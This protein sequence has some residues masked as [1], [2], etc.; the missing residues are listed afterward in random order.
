[1][2]VLFVLALIV[3]ASASR[4]A[5]ATA[6]T[7]AGSNRV[8]SPAVV[9]YW[10]SRDNGD[11]TGVLDLLVLWRGSPAWFTRGSGSSGGGGS[12]GGFGRWYAYQWMS[13]GDITLTIEL[14]SDAKGF[15]ADT[16]TAAILG[17]EI[18]L[19]DANVVL[20]DGADSGNPTIVGTRHVDPWF[21]GNDPVSAVVRRSPELFEFLRCDITL[22]DSR[23]QTMMTFVCGRMRP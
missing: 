12:S 10:Q 18:S 20:I 6:Q 1:M 4:S 14:N 19:R 23:M 16:T 8:L 7:S 22:P 5:R 9:S 13:Y 21:T 11:G 17:Q 15:P 3:A 2:R